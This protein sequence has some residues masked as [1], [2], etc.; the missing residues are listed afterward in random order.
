MGNALSKLSSE[1]PTFKVRTDEETNQTILSGMGELHLE[2]LMDR[3][4]RE[5][6]VE[7]NVGKPEVAYRETINQE[8]NA[9]A[10]FVRQSGGRGQF[11][12]VELTAKPLDSGEGFKFVN[13][14]VGGVIPREYIPA[15]EQGVKEA[16]ENGVVA[17]YPM[18]DIEVTVHDGSFHAVDSSEL[19]FKIAGSMAFKD[20]AKKAKP[21]LLEPIMDTEVICPMDFLGDVMGLSL[22]H[23]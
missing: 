19:A 22:I 11:G 1:D 17:G 18:V 6:S 9:R 7:A 3:L 2:V 8:T 16:M 21:I 14:L 5:Y 23:I 10:R 4:F 12:D 13:K 20:A 15:V